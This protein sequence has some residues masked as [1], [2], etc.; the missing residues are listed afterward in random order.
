MRFSVYLSSFSLSHHDMMTDPAR[1]GRPGEFYGPTMIPVS[2]FVWTLRDTVLYCYSKRFKEAIKQ[3]HVVGLD[4]VRVTTSP[5]STPVLTSG[6]HCR[7]SSHC[8][9]TRSMT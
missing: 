4:S 9:T 6:G 2:V 7:I 3:S 5:V 1:H 8:V